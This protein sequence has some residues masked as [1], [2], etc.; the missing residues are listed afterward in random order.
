MSFSV[1]TH[2]LKQLVNAFLPPIAWATMI[3]LFSSQH[4]LPGPEVIIVDFVIKKSAHIFV[5]AILYVL[6]YRA[7]RIALARPNL[8]T[9]S[10]RFW[11]LPFIICLVYAISDEFH[12]S[13]VVG[14]TS[15]VRD[16]GYDMLG[17]FISFLAI[18]RYL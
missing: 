1:T 17:T 11:L 2:T 13:L 12:Q 9:S 10:T 7:I 4:N 14:R 15:T 5:Y 16:V 8:S 6:L 18:H 3:F